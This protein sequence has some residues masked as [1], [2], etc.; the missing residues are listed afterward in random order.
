MNIDYEQNEQ[1]QIRVIKQT[2]VWPIV[3][4][5]LLASMLTLVGCLAVS[6]ALFTKK[7][8]TEQHGTEKAPAWENKLSQIS[9]LIDQY[10]IG[11]TDADKLADAA[12]SGM[13]DGLGDEWSWITQMPC[14]TRWPPSPTR[15]AT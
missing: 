9:N 4:A 2:R 8:E 7:G 5:A 3:L 1:S 13:I 14:L 10:F 11:E 12:A 6:G 15:Q